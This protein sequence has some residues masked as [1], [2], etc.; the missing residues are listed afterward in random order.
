MTVY[1]KLFT[2]SIRYV[3]PARFAI[4]SKVALYNRLRGGQF[5]AY[6]GVHQE[7]VIFD[8]I[9]DKLASIERTSDI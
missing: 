1:T 8:A 7:A 6:T 5:D 4:F 9:V 3:R 2:P